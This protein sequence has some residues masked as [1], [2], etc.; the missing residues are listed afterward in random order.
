METQKREE[1]QEADYPNRRRPWTAVFLSLIMPGLGQVYCGAIQSGI[2]V[3][4]VIVVFSVLWMVGVMHPKTPFLP[5]SLMIWGVISLA[6]IFAA[7]DA[8]RRARRTRYDYVLKD[9]NHWAIYLMLVW[10]A[11]AGTIGYGAFF[12]E[13]M[14]EAFVVPVNS[15]APTVMAGDRVIANKMA[16]NRK[17]PDYGDVVL[18]K[19][20]E[21][22]KSSNIKRVVALAGDTVEMKEGQLLINGQRLKRERIEKKTIQMKSQP[23]EGE[24]FWEKNGDVKYQIFVSGQTGDTEIA[25]KDFGSVTVPAHHCFVMADNRNHPKDSR[26]HGPLSLGALKGKFTQVYWPLQHRATLGAHQ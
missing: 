2:A 3:M 13:N 25:T 7:M 15:M 9:Y 10:I 5:F 23:V 17:D 22:R 8:Y 19:N 11:S 1:L 26:T 12:K 14:F 16:Y 18:F 4:G 24:M 20:P 6:T 21:N